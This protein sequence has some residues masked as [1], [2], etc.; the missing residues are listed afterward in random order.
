MGIFIL[1][2][3]C[4]TLEALTLPLYSTVRNIPGVQFMKNALNSFLNLF[5]GEEFQA[6]DLMETISAFGSPVSRTY[7]LH[8][9]N[10]MFP[11]GKQ[12]SSSSHILGWDNSASDW[13][14]NETNWRNIDKALDLARQHGVKLI[15]P[16]I[17]QDYGSSDTNWVGNFADLIRHRYNIQNY[18]IAQQAVDWFT[19]REMIKCYKQMISFYLNRINTFNGIRIG[20]DPTILAFETGNEMNWGYQN[21]SN[22]H[23]RPARANWTIEIAQFIKSLAP[24][25]LVMDGS[26][27]RNPKLAWEEE[28]LASPFVDLFSYHF[29]RPSTSPIL[30]GRLQFC[31]TGYA[32]GEG[33]TLPYH[34]WQ[35]SLQNQV[36]AHGKTFIVGEH[37]FYDKPAV[38]EAFYKNVT[39]AGTLVWSLRS[40]SE[41]GGFVTHGEGHNISSYHAPG[42][43]N[44][45][46]EK[47]DTQEADVISSTYDASYRIL[48]LEPPPKPIPG[49]PEAFLVSNGTHAGISWRGAAWAQQYEVLG[50]IFQDAQFS[51]ISRFVPDNVEDGQLFVPLD[52][53]DPTKPIHIALPEP[54][55][56]QSHAGWIDT[57]W[58]P[59]GSSAPCG[60]IH[61]D[62]QEDAKPP[63]TYRRLMPMSPPTEQN[64]TKSH[65]LNPTSQNRLISGG[66]FSVR[67]VSADGVPGGISESVFL[68]TQWEPHVGEREWS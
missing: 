11:D 23:D 59:P 51:T 40:H 1:M 14:Y 32:D 15:I 41:N 45:T 67:A 36:R 21:G 38:W 64:S 25:T 44:Q 7:T 6:R 16:I 19:D 61:F 57:K 12:K 43:R 53:T 66:W 54:I 49:T 52:P 4:S 17:N 35:S 30:T 3:S 27:S 33:E 10:G 55:P 37:G 50:A 18:T 28:A 48:G 60:D 9:A 31:A 29:L 65:E 56:H 8:V 5:T 39:C 46:S 34:D 63:T 2:E 13:V 24:K 22:A 68:K 20:D 26:Y 62:K 47:F 42:F 58:C